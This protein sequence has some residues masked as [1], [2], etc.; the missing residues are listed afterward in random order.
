MA[1]SAAVDQS[2]PTPFLDVAAALCLD[3]DPTFAEKAEALIAAGV[4]AERAK[5]ALE[6]RALQP[7]PRLTRIA[8]RRSCD[9]AHGAD[10][11]HTDANGHFIAGAM[12][13][14]ILESLSHGG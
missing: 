14:A 13:R 12:V 2:Y 6:A 1:S 11:S 9:M 4:N 3:S 5:F 7:D 8:Q 10:F